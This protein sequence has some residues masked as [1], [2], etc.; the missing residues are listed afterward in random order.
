[1]RSVAIDAARS[2]R[3]TALGRL[4]VQAFRVLL[5][6]VSVTGSAVHRL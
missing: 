5:L 4:A 1:M 2:E 3:I 6:L